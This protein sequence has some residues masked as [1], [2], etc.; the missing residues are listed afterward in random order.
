MRNLSFTI[1]AIAVLSMLGRRLIVVNAVE[2][3][4]QCRQ[5]IR[6]MATASELYAGDNSDCYPNSLQQ[7]VPNYLS[8]LPECPVPSAGRSRYQYLE[9]NN[10]KVFTICCRGNSHILAGER[11]N[12]PQYPAARCLVEQ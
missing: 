6:Q 5:Q 10:P 2:D 8:S 1:L 9:N 7:L 11:P 4:D 3:R 12:F